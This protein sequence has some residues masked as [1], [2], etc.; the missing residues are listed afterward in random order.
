MEQVDRNKILV[1][2]LI[3]K[4]LAFS[5]KDLGKKLGYGNESSFSQVINGKVPMPKDFIP[6]INILYPQINTKWLLTGEG[7]MLLPSDHSPVISG[8]C[9]TQVVGN[10]NNVN[11]GDVL[12]KTLAEMKDLIRQQ[13]ESNAVLVESNRMLVDSNKKLVDL[14]ADKCSS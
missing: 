8:D 1:R 14:L 13:M 6:K 4:G 5:Q 9:N 3:S 2:Y 12:A 7:E 10:S 11:G